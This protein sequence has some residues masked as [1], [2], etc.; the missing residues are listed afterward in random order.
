V[1]LTHAI[2]DACVLYPAP[3]RDFLMECAVTE[4]YQPHWS[5]SIHDEWIRNLLANRPDLDPARVARTRTLMDR[6]IP[7]A[8][9]TGYEPLIDSLTLP[10]PDDRH[11]LAAAI[12]AKASV[13]VTFNLRH[14]PAAALAPYGVSAQRPDL[15]LMQAIAGQ[16]DTFIGMAQRHRAR[17]TN[18]PKDAAAY[19]ATLRENHL[20]QVA[21]LLAQHQ[22]Q[23]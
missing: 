4:F 5:S 17:L 21:D 23:I 3:L 12:H 10:D 15:F 9:V 7:Q 19:I 1:P 20:A 18:P 13:I 14:F 16:T 6:A 11:V 22:S 8:L 2:L